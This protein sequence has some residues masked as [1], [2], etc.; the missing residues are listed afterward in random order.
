MRFKILL[1]CLVASGLLAACQPHRLPPHL[2]L[3]TKQPAPVSAAAQ[4]A[5]K[6]VGIYK[7]L[8][9]AADAPAIDSTLYLNTDG[10]FKL[11]DEY[12]GK[13]TN[14]QV[15][16][17]AA[18]TDGSATMTTTGQLDKKFDKPVIEQVRFTDD[19]D[20]TLKVDRENGSQWVRF[21]ALV[22]DYTKETYD[23]KAATKAIKTSGL[24]DLYKAALP[25]ADCCGLDITL[26]LNANKSAAFR[27]DYL[28]GKAPITEVGTWT[29]SAT[30]TLTST[31]PV[32]VTVVM[33]GQKDQPAAAKPQTL[34]L[35]LQDGVL[36]TTK[37]SGILPDGRLKLYS[38]VGLIAPERAAFTA[39]Q[40]AETPAQ[41]KLPHYPK[42]LPFWVRFL[43]TVERI[44]QKLLDMHFS[45]HPFSDNF[46]LPTT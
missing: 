20:E 3:A 38:A 43:M 17:W 29:A 18:N 32:T 42:H 13:A 7:Q 27:S 10:S 25:A 36:V 35:V 4:P 37:T 31:A 23:P 12:V 24:A 1:L 41:P 6:F 21:E 45:G 30:Q 16:A 33:T 34:Q 5:P 22:A 2:R 40:P 8:S 44:C 26:F 9:L 19:T 46:K 14:T 11:I 15:G 39:Q 28:N